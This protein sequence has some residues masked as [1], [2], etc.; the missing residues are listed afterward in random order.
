MSWSPQERKKVCRA[1]TMFFIIQIAPHAAKP[2]DRNNKDQLAAC[3]GTRKQSI[4]VPGR[5]PES[6]KQNN[7]PA[8]SFETKEK[9]CQEWTTN[10]PQFSGPAIKVVSHRDAI[11][12]PI[13][14]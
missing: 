8:V 1:E 5:P 2:T 9:I 12:W 6:I 3:G 4:Q 7:Y 10:L 14:W 11:R 13:S